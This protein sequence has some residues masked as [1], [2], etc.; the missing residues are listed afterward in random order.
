MKNQKTFFLLFNSFPEILSQDCL[1][2]SSKT[3]QFC[4]AKECNIGNYLYNL[5][6]ILLSILV[7]KN[8]FKKFPTKSAKWNLIS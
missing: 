6:Y 1:S 8:K 7:T 3:L 2:I 4:H 5:A